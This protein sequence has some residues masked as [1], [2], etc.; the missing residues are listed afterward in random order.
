MKKEELV[1]KWI[2]ESLENFKKGTSY[3]KKY[4]GDATQCMSGYDWM[5]VG[6]YMAVGE[7]LMLCADELRISIEQDKKLK[8]EEEKC[9]V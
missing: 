3:I 5:Y 6:Q 8:E 4:E 1:T 9:S 7:E 2:T